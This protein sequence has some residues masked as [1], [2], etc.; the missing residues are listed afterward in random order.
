MR[1][2]VL[3]M[4]M[5]KPTSWK[6][7]ETR[8]SCASCSSLVSACQI[9]KGGRAR[10]RVVDCER[11]ACARGGKKGGGGARV[12]RRKVVGACLPA[13]LVLLEALEKLLERVREASVPVGRLVPAQ[14]LELALQPI[15]HL[16]LELRPLRAR[17][18]G[19]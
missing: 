16:A 18:R 19:T 2:R 8:S 5:G 15:L 11:C 12:R 7:A 17:A 14:L 9:R 13:A 6:V 10:V 3:A 4:W 1:R